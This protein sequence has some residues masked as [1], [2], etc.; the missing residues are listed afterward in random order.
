MTLLFCCLQNVQE[1]LGLW[2][3]ETRRVV[4][5]SA[6]CYSNFDDEELFRVSLATAISHETIL[7][8]NVQDRL[9]IIRR[10]GEGGCKAWLG[11]NT[12]GGGGAGRA[13]QGRGICTVAATGCLA[14]ARRCVLETVGCCCAA[15]ILHPCLG[16]A[17]SGST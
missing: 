6:T 17:T 14:Q 12:F 9:I 16:W 3:D 10:S 7:W 2:E 4:S 8:S 13:G 15:T 1:Q 5:E 11:P